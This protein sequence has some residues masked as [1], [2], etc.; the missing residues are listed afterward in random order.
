MKCVCEGERERE[1]ERERRNV[2]KFNIVCK[3][4]LRERKVFRESVGC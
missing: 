4:C 1:R 2:T 3:L